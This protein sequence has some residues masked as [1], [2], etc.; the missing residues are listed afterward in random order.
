MKAKNP[1]RIGRNGRVIHFY[2]KDEWKRMNKH[3]PAE[4]GFKA[5]KEELKKE[6]K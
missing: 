3:S 6:K 1:K 4:E 2:T 5:V